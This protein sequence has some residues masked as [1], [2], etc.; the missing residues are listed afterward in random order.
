MKKVMLIHGPN[1]NL[2][3]QL[4]PQMASFAVVNRACVC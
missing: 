3:G 1:L 4:L 2:T